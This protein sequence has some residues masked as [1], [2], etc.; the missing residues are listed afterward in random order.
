MLRA[1]TIVIL[2]AWLSLSLSTNG[3]T[4][5]TSSTTRNGRT[6]PVT[7]LSIIPS[8]AEPGSSV[9]LYGSGFNDNLRAFLGN[10]EV[11]ARVLG[12][13]QL[14]FQI[15]ALS[16]GL[17]ALYIRRG[18]GM[19]SK[20]YNFSVIPLKPVVDGLSPDRV[21]ACAEGQDREVEIIGSNFQERS[22]VLFDGAIV[23]SR[24][25]S[26]EAISVTVPK[27]A[28]GLHNIQVKNPGD[29]LSSVMALF[30]DSM[31]E[32][33]SV[34][35]GEE[36]VNYYNLIIEGKN[37]QSTSV[38][39]VDGKRLSASSPNIYERE[40]VV[41]MDCTRLV[42]ER[43]P[44]DTTPKSFTV[45]VLNADGQESSVVQVTAP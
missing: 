1:L 28:G 20:V 13:R 25:L 9:T 40:R 24:N 19:T 33:T 31:P 12:P 32:I 16:P 5:E 21:L 29:A 38:V 27:V 34:S 42:Y 11:T 3:L 41:F 44:Y 37:F 30:I 36:S 6:V 17:Y 26:P 10:T 39:L 8:Q 15:P 22:R 45:Q 14:V 43:H 35:R 18:D 23:K 2:A 7:I 4:A